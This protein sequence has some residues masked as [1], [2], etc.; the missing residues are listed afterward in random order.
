MM[1]TDLDEYPNKINWAYLVRDLLSRM[2]FYLVWL[3]QGV[4]NVYAFLNLFKQRLTDYFTQNWH[5]RLSISSRANFYTHIAD[6][7]PKVYLNSVKVLKIRNSL[8]RLC[9]HPI[10]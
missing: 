7:R 6:F 3:N 1:L 10:D 2:G 4:G 8:A 5:E 9:V